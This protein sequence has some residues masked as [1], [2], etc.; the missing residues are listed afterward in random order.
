MKNKERVAP[1]H[2]FIYEKATGSHHL[3]L[4]DSS[5]TNKQLLK[6]IKSKLGLS[7]S[8]SLSLSHEGLPLKQGACNGLQAN[9]TITLEHNFTLRGGSEN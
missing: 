7:V 9:A 3:L 1:K 4:V 5:L 6:R 8:D 2:F